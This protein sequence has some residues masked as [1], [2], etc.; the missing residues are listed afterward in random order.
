MPHACVL[1]SAL[2]LGIGFGAIQ[3]ATGA[4][5]GGAGPDRLEG[6]AQ[7]TSFTDGGGTTVRGSRAG[8]LL[9]GGPGRDRLSGDTGADRLST[10]GTGGATR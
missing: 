7:P 10:G 6:T 8:D 5:F 1:S 2:L 3:A 4:I 9:N